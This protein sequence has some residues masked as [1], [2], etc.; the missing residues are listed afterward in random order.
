MIKSL[1]VIAVLTATGCTPASKLHYGLMDSADY[2]GLQCEKL[3]YVTQTDAWRQ[4]TE[5]LI[6]SRSSSSSS[7]TSDNYR[8]QRNQDLT[9]Q[10]GAGGCTPNFGTG[11]CL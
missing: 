2:Y 8:Q 4:C 9:R 6:K 1:V 3:G 11:G 10:H 7:A 5:S